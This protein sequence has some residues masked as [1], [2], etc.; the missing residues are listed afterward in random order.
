MALFAGK[1]KVVI[2]KIIKNRRAGI[3]TGRGQDGRYAH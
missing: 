1:R 2:S 3:R